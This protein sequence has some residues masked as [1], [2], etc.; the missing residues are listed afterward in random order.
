MSRRASR[1]ESFI[2]RETGGERAVD[3]IEGRSPAGVVTLG[4]AG[5][6]VV[7][8]EGK[9][10]PHRLAAAAFNQYLREEGLD[11]LRAT[12]ESAQ[13]EHFY[14]FAKTLL[15]PGRA[16]TIPPPLGFRLELQPLSSP[17]AQ[18]PVKMVLLLDGKPLENALITAYQRDT[19][20]K[21]TART[22]RSGAVTLDLGSGV[23][24]LKSTHVIRADAPTHDWE[25]LWASLT[26][27]R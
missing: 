23:W 19:Q 7:G 11:H 17:F 15:H 27:E 3:G 13:R 12:S 16:D 24:L 1:I 20:Q 8:Y 26:F 25:S 4:D 21:L 14:R 9:A 6:A 2:V 5:V 10:T 18:R 22:N